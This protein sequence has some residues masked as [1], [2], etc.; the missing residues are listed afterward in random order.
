MPTAFDRNVLDS[1]AFEEIH[2]EAI[3]HVDSKDGS[4]M[5]KQQQGPDGLGPYAE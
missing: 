4:K 2:L 3:S 5:S 1:R